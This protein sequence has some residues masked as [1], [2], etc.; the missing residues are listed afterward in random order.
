M[1]KIIFLLSCW[2]INLKSFHMQRI[3]ALSLL[4]IHR[5]TEVSTEEDFTCIRVSIA[6]CCWHDTFLPIL[7]PPVVGSEHVI[8][9]SETY[10]SW[11]I[12][13][14]ISFNSILKMNLILS[15]WEHSNRQRFHSNKVCDLFQLCYTWIYST[16]HDGLR[17]TS[18]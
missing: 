16:G 1:V 8:L 18:G 6:F 5:V 9:K 10:S 3:E 17:N 2:R 14:H 4:K 12:R 11:E 13:L 7:P 15:L